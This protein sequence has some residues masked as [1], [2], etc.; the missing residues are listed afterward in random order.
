VA[1]VGAGGG[2]GEEHPA[3][4]A[5][6]ITRAISAALRNCLKQAIFLATWDIRSSAA[7]EIK[8]NTTTGK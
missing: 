1:T 2:G 8:H 3:T 7:V 5:P 6:G 4:S